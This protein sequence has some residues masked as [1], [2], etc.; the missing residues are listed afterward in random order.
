MIIKKNLD[1]AVIVTVGNNYDQSALAC[2][3]I[4]MQVCIDSF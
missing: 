2:K 3:Y 1:T 4:N